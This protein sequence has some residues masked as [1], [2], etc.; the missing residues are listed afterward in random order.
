MG[1]ILV[2]GIFLFPIV[3]VLGLLLY[4][5]VKNQDKKIAER[6][7]MEE[8]LKKASQI[9]PGMHKSDVFGLIGNNCIVSFLQD[10]TEVCEWKIKEYGSTVITHNHM[11]NN[12]FSTVQQS[13]G[14]EFS[15]RVAFKDNIAIEIISGDRMV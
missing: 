7:A 8:W 3:L 10:N 11:G 2:Y 14:N 9:R 12:T 1:L 4:H 5:A 15:F 6:K 13:N